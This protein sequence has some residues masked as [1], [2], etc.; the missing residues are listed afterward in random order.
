MPAILDKNFTFKSFE[1]NS[2]Q[3]Y[4]PLGLG[5][6]VSKGSS[7]VNPKENRKGELCERFGRHLHPW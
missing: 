6:K 2:L 5:I 4:Q 1:C 3:K 7:N